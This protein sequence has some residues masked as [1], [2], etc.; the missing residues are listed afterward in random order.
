MPTL[1][2]LDIETTGL[3]PQADAI[4]EIGARRFNGSRVEDEWTTLVNPGRHIPEFIT[5]LT[6]IEDA[7]VRQAPRLQEVLDD[8]AAFIGD[9]PIV[10]HNIPFDLSFFRKHGLFELHER[11]DTYEMASVLLPTAS[12]YNLGALGQL[13]GIAL[14][15]THRALDD[16]RVTHAVFHRLYTTA[17]ELPPDLLAEIVRH[18]EPLE[19]NGA[20]VFRQALRARSRESVKAKQVRQRDS[21]PLFTP[22]DIPRVP[23]LQVPDEPLPIDAEEAA[24][25]LE[26]GGPFSSYFDS[27]EHR[28]E[29]VAML[30]A[31]ANALSYSQHLL[32]E[33]GTGVGKS[34]AYLVPAALFA[35]QNNTRVVISTNT[36]NLQDQL[37]KKDIPDLREA[38]GLDLRA[39][40]LKGRSNYF[41]PRRFELL[42]R[43]GPTNSD[44]MRVLAKLLV[45]LLENTSGDRTEINLTGPSEREVWTHISAED[46]ACTTDTCLERTGGACPFF[47]ARQAAQTS[48][49]LIVNHALLL[50]DVAV[51]HRVLP[52]YDYLIIDEG[53]HL[54]SATTDALSFRLT[55]FDT[56]R[57]IKEIGGSSAGVLGHLLTTAHNQV[58]PSDFAVLNQNVSRA[59]DLAWR[60][61]SQFR[62]FFEA[63]SEF[64]DFIREGQQGGQYAWQERILPSTRTL[65]GWDS[66]EITWDAAGETLRLLIALLG[67]IQKG[68]ADLYADGLEALEDTI[69]NLGN[70][71]RR[72]M[73]AESMVNAMIFEPVHDYVY[74]VEVSPN[75]GR[76][77]LNAAP[78]R[79]GPLV[80][81]YLWHE[82]RCVILTSAT[83]TTNN[84]FNYLRETLSADEADELALGSPFDYESAALLY[85]ANDIAEP[86]APNYQHQLEQTLVQLCTTT[87]GRTLVLFTS[88]AQ[89]KRTA[90]SISGPLAQADITVYEQG[91]GASPNALLETFKSSERAVLLGTRSFWEGVDVPGEALSVLVIVKLPFAVP[92]DPLV[93]ARAETFEDPFHE[94]HLPEAILR[95]RQGFGRLIRTQL[96]RG[97]VA[98]LD[99]RLLTKSYGRAFLDSL[100][101]CTSRAAS[102]AELPRSAAKWLNL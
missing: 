35:L 6:G 57:L 16:A 47:R 102:L 78:V 21:G 27:Y 29:Q 13:L 12:R 10:G 99:R 18:S 70:S 73:E 8:L 77:A 46:D 30:K 36:I 53:H 66:V 37:I 49:I 50:A 44:E 40:V 100:P 92:S 26:Y 60:L 9:S 79:V 82:K 38:L 20:W 1:V 81:K 48:H 41:C 23:P 19:W 69:S 61:E 52:E 56:E 51:G 94:Y 86:N 84:E 32:V 72:L 7:M 76:L 11:I 15:A 58:R 101:Q 91:E 96:D 25:V 90:R 65:P 80:E 31:V 24:S 54:E 43:R 98:I 87:G 71:L 2:A 68:A 55:Q 64:V 42:R 89:L 3:D 34:F 39:S 22:A 97:V 28:P 67:D 33:A 83:L 5:G 95:F 4:I 45:W 93:A 74:W 75:G 63:L 17:R 59:T 88:Y 14:P 62:S 85:I